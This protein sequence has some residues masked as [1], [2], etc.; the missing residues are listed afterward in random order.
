M[1]AKP[2]LVA[3]V[4]FAALV[5]T[6]YAEAFT[7]KDGTVITG[8]VARATSKGKITIR[9]KKGIL[10]Y[11]IMAFDDATRGEHFADLEA[12]VV[13]RRTAAAEEAEETSRRKAPLPEPKAEPKRV[14]ADTNKKGT[15]GG[16]GLMMSGFLLCAIG[17]IWFIVAGFAESV[18]WGIALIVFNGIAGLPFLFLHWDRA[19]SPVITW[20]VGVALIISGVILAG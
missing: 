9:T 14:A 4:L 17:S 18:W 6:A 2:A 8:K 7:L 20:L 10:N 5:G 11:N 3:G 16:F 15:A 13:R 1:R 19:K 12:D